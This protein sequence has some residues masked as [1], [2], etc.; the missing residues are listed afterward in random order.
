MTRNRPDVDCQGCGKVHFM[1]PAAMAVVILAFQDGRLHTVG[2]HG[3]LSPLCLLDALEMP[4]LLER[5]K[6]KELG[7]TTVERMHAT[8]D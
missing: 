6:F 3:V 2:K 8:A 1:S 5:F 4:D 7:V